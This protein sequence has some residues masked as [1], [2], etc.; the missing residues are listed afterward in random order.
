MHKIILT[1]AVGALALTGCDFS[2]SA[3]SATPV[4]ISSI[5][6]SNLQDRTWDEGSNPDVFVEIRNLAGRAY[7]RS[8]PIQNADVSGTLTFAIDEAIEV[9]PP[10]APLI[11][12]VFDMDEDLVH[13][14]VMGY[15]TSF[16]AAELAAGNVERAAGNASVVLRSSASTIGAD[17]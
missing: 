12:G 11:V 1:A 3:G 8:A 16:T 15:T 5:E 9:G 4:S 6:V 2:E 7:Y 14:D 13:S 17:L 10:T